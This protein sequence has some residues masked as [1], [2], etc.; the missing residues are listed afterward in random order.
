[1]TCLSCSL[2]HSVFTKYLD[3]QSLKKKK[4]KIVREYCETFVKA[5]I[6]PL[7]LFKF[8]P[9]DWIATVDRQIK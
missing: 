7:V 3:N 9:L 4:K 8:I 1:M 5:G 6:F 2:L